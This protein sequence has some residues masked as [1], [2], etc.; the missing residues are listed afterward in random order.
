MLWGICS[1]AYALK[2]MLCGICSGAYALRHIKIGACFEPWIFT[3]LFRGRSSL[4]VSLGY[5]FKPPKRCIFGVISSWVQ[6]FSVYPVIY[7]AYDMHMICVWYEDDMHM[8]C[9]GYAH[10]IRIM[11]VWYPYDMH[12]IYV[13]Y[14]Y[15]MGMIS[16]FRYLFGHWIFTFLFRGRSFLRASSEYQ[17]HMARKICAKAYAQRH[18]DRSISLKAYLVYQIQAI[19]RPYIFTFLFKGRST[20]R[21]NSGP[22]HNN[23]ITTE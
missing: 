7:L 14:A 5:P 20:L 4:R 13:W 21:I 12:M 22:P 10:D 15:D 2:H 9:V 6:T 18:V 11:C 16:G 1:K 23:Q 8:I 3:F 19:L 17:W